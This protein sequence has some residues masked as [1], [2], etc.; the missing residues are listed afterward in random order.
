MDLDSRRQRAWHL[1][2]RYPFAQ[3]MLGVYVAVVE[4]WGSLENELPPP[5]ELASWAGEKMLPGVVK[6]TEA[7]APQPLAVATHDLARS[8]RAV[9]VLA[10]WLAGQELG[11][12]ER[13]LARACLQAPLEALR[14]EAGTACAA[15]P[16]PRGGRHCPRCG[17]LPQLS[18]RA[19]A[20][21]PLVRGQRQLSCARCAHRWQYSASSCPSC[22]E[23]TG[24]RR[25]VYA[26]KHDGPVVSRTA[27]GGTELF[28]HLSIDACATCQRYLIDVDSG[29]D[30]RA[31][32][33]VD[34]L[35]ALPLDLYANEQGLSKVTPN[36]MGF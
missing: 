9:E 13:F 31:V 34:E 24:A 19:G 10:G 15:D 36:L 11:P 28:A 35:V 8:G 12:A 4:V 22:G 7:A 6:A 16:A 21:D 26:E 18:I 30:A 20:D 32:P 25:T 27:D 29:R 5:G 14:E 33:E 17:G 23:S 3:Q 2:E 1:R